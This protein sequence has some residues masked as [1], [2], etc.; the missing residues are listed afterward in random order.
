MSTK[1]ENNNKGSWSKPLHFLTENGVNE[2]KR[3]KGKLMPFQK[4][5]ENSNKEN[6]PLKN[7]VKGAAALK[8]TK[9]IKIKSRFDT[10]N[11]G[12]GKF[13]PSP[14]QVDSNQK[15][16]KKNVRDE[17]IQGEEAVEA[18]KSQSFTK[19]NDKE[20][21]SPNQDQSSTKKK[22][23]LLRSQF[24]EI[25]VC[26]AC[27][28]LAYKLME[29]YHVERDL[30]TPSVR[31]VLEYYNKNGREK[32][33]KKY[34]FE[35]DMRRDCPAD[36]RS[37]PGDILYI[38]PFGHMQFKNCVIVQNDIYKGELL[39]DTLAGDKL[40]ILT[41][42]PNGTA[43]TESGK[44]IS[45]EKMKYFFS[46]IKKEISPPNPKCK[47][48]RS[49]DQVKN[50][51][52]NL[53]CTNKE[54]VGFHSIF[55]EL[56][57]LSKR[58]RDNINMKFLLEAF[59]LKCKNKRCSSRNEQFIKN[60]LHALK[61][62]STLSAE[63]TKAEYL[64][65]L[66]DDIYVICQPVDI[67]S[68]YL[69]QNLNMDIIKKTINEWITERNSDHVELD[70]DGC[71]SRVVNPN[72]MQKKLS[73]FIHQTVRRVY[74]YLHPDKTIGKS[75]KAKI[76]YADT[77]DKIKNH[78]DKIKKFLVPEGI[79]DN[80]IIVN[81][82]NIIAI[83]ATT[84]AGCE[85][86][87]EK[88]LIKPSYLGACSG[89]IPDE[90]P[91]VSLKSITNGTV[92]TDRTDRTDESA[93]VSLE[94]ALT[95]FGEEPSFNSKALADMFKSNP[96][97]LQAFAMCIETSNNEKSNSEIAFA[98]KKLQ[99]ISSNPTDQENLNFAN[100][101]IE[102]SFPEEHRELFPVLGQQ[103]NK[104]DSK[105]ME[106][107]QV[108][109]KG[110]EAISKIKK[111]QAEKAALE[112][113]RSEGANAKKNL[114]TYVSKKENIAESREKM[115]EIIVKYANKI[116]GLLDTPNRDPRAGQMFIE[117]IQLFS[118][119]APDGISEIIQLWARATD[120]QRNSQEFAKKT[121]KPMFI[122]AL[123]E[124]TFDAL[125]LYKKHGA[126]ESTI[127][128]I[129]KSQLKNVG[130][131]NSKEKTQVSHC[132]PDETKISAALAVTRQCT[133]YV[134]ASEINMIKASKEW[135]GFKFKIQSRKDEIYEII[136]FRPHE[137][138]DVL[139]QALQVKEEAY[140]VLFKAS[141]IYTI[142]DKTFCRALNGEEYL[143]TVR[144][145]FLR[146]NDSRV[147]NG[148]VILGDL[149]LE[150][151]NLPKFVKDRVGDDV[152]P[153]IGVVTDDKIT[154]IGVGNE[155]NYK[156]V[157]NS[158]REPD[159]CKLTVYDVGRE[160]KKPN[161]YKK[162]KNNKD[163][164]LDCLAESVGQLSL[165]ESPR[166]VTESFKKELEALE[167]RNKYEDLD[168]GDVARMDWLRR[169]IENPVRPP[170]AKQIN[171]I[172]SALEFIANGA[173]SNG[174]ES[175]Q[176]AI[177]M[178]MD[179]FDVWIHPDDRIEYTRKIDC[180]ELKQIIKLSLQDNFDKESVPLID[181]INGAINSY[182]NKIDVV[183][184][185]KKELSNYSP[186]EETNKDK[187]IK[188]EKEIRGKQPE[189]KL[190][191]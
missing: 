149:K 86:S 84:I 166:A 133:F 182:F 82:Q 188:R 171:K 129:K 170:K 6:V 96:E 108:V 73:G 18:L 145:V 20:N 21:T 135:K 125:D 141:D 76:L 81:Y 101:L 116:N 62:L 118:N 22:G 27:L 168:E 114:E 35:L 157:L 173:K 100:T 38:D 10:T 11:G 95:T 87:D 172:V 167:K 186:I 176:Q 66:I 93:L 7:N 13:M 115:R 58:G 75:E 143:I 48:L 92:E 14:K 12:K 47:L 65:K 30:I 180:D 177:Q 99:L 119:F 110:T 144:H 113:E 106:L 161:G 44:I 32:T 126:I 104:I 162:G 50:I 33:F 52:F 183:A 29:K 131:P 155:R 43:I 77:L 146:K 175:L 138:K 111:I 181:K 37:N 25:I 187:K 5:V 69:E 26:A 128:R 89:I 1:T 61:K 80:N 156:R 107:C 36:E 8:N 78:L 24:P 54:C 51:T 16:V 148:N 105:V 4:Q 67:A 45:S 40:L 72:G 112:N 60:G 147:K 70:I 102:H 140:Y 151:E 59:E 3:E 122:K 64:R 109:E 23:N 83:C 184:A 150:L 154:E 169:Q 85:K 94:K 56:L 134:S 98:L 42:E 159:S 39:D 153:I 46:Q 191:C 53:R 136:F 31:T 17:M 71:I 124:F 142:E 139:N 88:L 165:N 74:R 178:V 79:V 28:A 9:F 185:R 158:L 63:K 160:S 127:N 152:L 190:V 19:K 179:C 91:K 132:L 49:F 2:T 15:N 68:K 103:T 164:D 121:L 130:T 117:C 174:D 120:D 41:S 97:Q 189:R 123:S 34:G 55:D 137:S 90:T 163:I 57:T